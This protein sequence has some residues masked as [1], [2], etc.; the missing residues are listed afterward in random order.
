MDKAALIT[1]IPELQNEIRNLID[2]I[3]KLLKNKLVE[4][5]NEIQ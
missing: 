5:N 4:F 2:V 1:R 3:V